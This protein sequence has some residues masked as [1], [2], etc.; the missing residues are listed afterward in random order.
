MSVTVFL[1]VLAAACLH[2][3]WNLIAKGGRRSDPL[4]NALLIGIGAAATGIPALFVTGLPAPASWPYALTSAVVHI[5]Y[6]LLAGA[7]YKIADLSAAYPLTRGAAPLGSALL[8]AWVL[9]EVLSVP[10]WIGIVLIGGGVVGLAATALRRGGLTRAGLGL[11]GANAVVIALYTLIDGQGARLSGNPAGYVLLLETLN[12]PMLAPALWWLLRRA[13][14]VGPGLR[15][16]LAGGNWWRGL[17]GG[18]MS[19]AAYGAALWAMTLAPIGMVAA[20]R[21]VSVLLGVLFGAAVLHE[22][23][24]AARWLA[25]AVIVAG[26]L[27][28]RLAG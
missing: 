17:L 10:S 27:L 20:L 24:G 7:A 28:L 11:A 14:P 23:V 19:I 9:G 13:G 5:A 18:A 3:G 12:A 4:I 26:M 21:E 6:F 8:A 16:V 22:R 1:V 2:A 25:A 15:R